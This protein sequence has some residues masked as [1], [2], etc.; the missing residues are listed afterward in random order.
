MKLSITVP[1]FFF[2][3]LILLASFIIRW[4]KIE[5]VPYGIEG[6]EAAWIVNSLLYKYGINGW[7]RDI[8]TH[9]DTLA[10]I[11]PLSLK[12]NQLSFII[13][14]TDYFSPKKLLVC[15]SVF[16]L[17]FFYFFSR[18]FLSK[19]AALIMLILYS[20]SSYKL[21]TSRIA[22]PHSF[23]E[24]F[25]YPVMLLLLNLTPKEKWRTLLFSFLAGVAISFVLLT[26]NLGYMLPGV[27]SLILLITI[28]QKRFNLPLAFFSLLLFILPL[29]LFAKLWLNGLKEEFATRTNVLGNT[30]I[31]FQTKSISTSHLFKSIQIIKGQFFDTLKYETADMLVSYP[32]PLINQIVTIA[33]LLGFILAFWQIRKTLPLITWL[34]I[35]GFTY[36]VLFGLNL[37]RMWFLTMGLIFT[38]AGVTFDKIFQLIQKLWLIPKITFLTVMLLLTSYIVY[39]DIKIFY[40]YAINNSSYRPQI[41]ESLMIVRKYKKNIGDS[42]IFV[43]HREFNASALNP[44]ISF[45]YLSRHP[46]KA[47]FLRRQTRQSIGSITEEEFEQNYLVYMR[48][49]NIII[50]DNESLSSTQHIIDQNSDCLY[51]ISRYQY[52]SEIILQRCTDNSRPT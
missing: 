14:G 11:F 6:D 39:S 1:E 37:P 5:T 15:L 47:T 52:Y 3:M 29:T 48:Q 28:V 44:I 31:N 13:F 23:S 50:T 46:D 32:A 19:K 27:G 16:S 12:I 45:Y 35:S 9:N 25:V 41:R 18:K 26:Y 40:K 21:I 36:H 30:L 49:N 33:F 4:Y 38:F 24:I 43:S 51:K 8:W 42:L 2:V 20:F 17:L 34:I 7:E 22:F 10:R